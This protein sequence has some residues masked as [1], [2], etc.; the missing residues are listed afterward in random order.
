MPNRPRKPAAKRPAT[1]LNRKTRP[2]REGS[3][4]AESSR[5]SSRS[6]RDATLDDSVGD[7]SGPRGGT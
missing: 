6:T 3:S 1:D 5:S 2:P 4:L 7:S